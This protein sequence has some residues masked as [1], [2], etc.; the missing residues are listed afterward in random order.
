MNGRGAGPVVRFHGTRGSVP[1]PDAANACT[2]GDTSCV[3]ILHDG[4]RVILDAGTGIR[5]LNRAI[6]PADYAAGID[7]FLTHFHWDHVQGL[8]FFAPLRDPAAHVRVHAPCQ[9]DM[10]LA[11]LLGGGLAPV[12]FPVPYHAFAALTTLHTVD[13]GPWVGVGVEVA[14]MRVVHPS[15]THAYRVRVDGV[16]VAYV[17][18]NELGDSAPGDSAYDALCSF[19]AGA[20]LLVHDAMLTDAE[21]PAKRGWGHSTFGQALRLAEDAGVR[22][23]R[24]FHHDPDRDDVA[25]EAIIEPIR[26][27]VGERGSGLIVNVAR[28]GEAVRL[29][30]ADVR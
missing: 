20:D 27:Q 9:D 14:S 16:V 22:E 26:D 6:T 30:R 25:L 1:T 28:D 12:Y 21:Y 2:G 18:D 23:L 19:V 24:F 15:N 3:E 4:G 13:D 17:P 11:E 29:G 8:P 5:R 7:I 10:C